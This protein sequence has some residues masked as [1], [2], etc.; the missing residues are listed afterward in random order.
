MERMMWDGKKAYTV[1]D[2]R[3]LQDTPP[4]PF[5]EDLRNLCRTAFGP[6]WTDKHPGQAAIDKLRSYDVLPEVFIAM[7]EVIGGE[8]QMHKL[9]FLPAKETELAGNGLVYCRQKKQSFAFRSEST[10]M[11]PSNWAPHAGI[12]VGQKSPYFPDIEWQRWCDW[13]VGGRPHT[14]PT[15]LLRQ[16]GE[17]LDNMMP[18]CV[19][20]QTPVKK[21]GKLSRYET[22]ARR[23]GCFTLESI[24]PCNW[25]FACDPERGLLLRSC[26]YERAKVLL[27]SRD[28]AQLEALSDI[29]PIQWRR[30]DDKKILDPAKFIQSP[31]PVTF[32]E[33]L[34][35]MSRALLG[36]RSMALSAEEVS[37]AEA[38]LG[39][40]FPEA[41]RQF[42]LHFGKGGKLFTTDAL[43]D[44]L[45]FRQ[46]DPEDDAFG[47]DFE[48]GM[49]QDSLLLAV[50]NQ[51]VWT[52]YLDLNTGEPW[53]D[54]GEGRED[55]W[56]LDL[57]GALLHLLAMN[58]TGFLSRG[59][60]CDM[61]DT[62]ENRELMGH[63]FHFL[64]EGKMA[65]FADPDKGLVGCRQNESQIVIMAHGEKGLNQLEEN[66][67]I[68]VSC[69]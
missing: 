50:E 55:C 36:K 29:C 59:G 5:K 18:N 58:A 54:W 67:D 27:Y 42:Y 22:M 34:E 66:A 60:D 47:E 65:V 6:D 45:T 1:E 56:G 57:E 31:A 68:Q 15:L 52:M 14:L 48:E 32:A 38:R 43:N 33:K 12:R 61:E 17:A 11:M 35:V 24:M 53:L 8:E 62:P 30:R 51:G 39:I 49:V 69:F 4:E 3:A 44:I 64:V 16:I 20:A 26:D 13:L 10:E 9:G 19:W 2:Y 23:F 7:Y 63:Y 41:L 40:Q 21:D 25:E 46:M 37:K 28:P